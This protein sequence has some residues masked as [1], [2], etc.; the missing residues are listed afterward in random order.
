MTLRR[1]LS[2]LLRFRAVQLVYGRLAGR[3]RYSARERQAIELRNRTR[4]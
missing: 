2:R 1:A 3:R 4:L